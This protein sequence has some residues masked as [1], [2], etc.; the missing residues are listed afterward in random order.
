MALDTISIARLEITKIYIAAFNRA[1]DAAGLSNW[2]NQYT[3][4][5]MTYKQISEDFS[6]Q[7]EYKAKYPSAMTNDEYITKI[8]SNVFGRTPDAGGLENWLAN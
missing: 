5:L 4:G 1:P 6:N 7:A 3:A 8:Y 2:M